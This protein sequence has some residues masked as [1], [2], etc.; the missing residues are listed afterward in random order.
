MT[1]KSGLVSIQ[2]RRQAGSVVAYALIAIFLMGL[3]LAAMTQ[4]V[5]QS[6]NTSHLNEIMQYVQV[7]IKTIQG[8]IG[9]C[10]QTYPG[11]VD[12][13]GNGIDD[14]NNPNVPFPLYSDLSSGAA[15][16]AIVSIKCP[17][18][19][20]GQQVIFSGNMG[21]PLKL[22]GDTTTYSTTYFTD[23]TEGSYI[24]ITRAAKDALWTEAISR[25]DGKYSACSV[26]V[27]APTGAGTCANGCLYY[28]FVR[29]SPGGGLAPK[30][31]CP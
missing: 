5:K 29:R 25:L 28:W 15:G 31:G 14:H 13:D 24:R 9:E 20:T 21:S 17:G 10:V 7:D 3:L 18:A 23:A 6:A 22:L 8:A 2:A 11:M 12:A 30:A 26:S 4:G 27:V 1:K 16:E 19:P